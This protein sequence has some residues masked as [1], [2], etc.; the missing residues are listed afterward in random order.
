MYLTTELKSYYVEDFRKLQKIT[1]PYWKLDSGVIDPCLKINASK[2]FRTL[3]SKYSNDI[4]W[5]VDIISYLRL[6]YTKS[7]ETL[8]K[9]EIIPIMT[10]LF[11]DNVKL[12]Y[13]FK[14][15]EDNEVSDYLHIG[16]FTNPDYFRIKSI[17]LELT[18]P[19]EDEHK[20]FW[21]NISSIVSEY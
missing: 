16:C 18:S 4:G 15:P 14:E 2:N 7:G 19:D 17:H 3:F 21:S 1:D 5:S 12:N 13:Y 9:N 6:A 8:L 10:S 11:S 20:L